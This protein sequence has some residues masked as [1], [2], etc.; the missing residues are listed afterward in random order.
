LGIKS[1]SYSL[2][3]RFKVSYPGP[4]HSEEEFIEKMSQESDIQLGTGKKSLC[5]VFTKKGEGSKKGGLRPE[6]G[7]GRKGPSRAE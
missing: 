4:S 3:L 1:F 5:T 7:G 2:R 6:N